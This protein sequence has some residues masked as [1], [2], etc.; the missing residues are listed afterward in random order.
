MGRYKFSRK[1]GKQRPLHIIAWEDANGRELPKGYVVHHIDGNGHNNDPSNLVAMTRGEHNSLHA[2]LKRE[3]K[4]PVDP[5]NPD[6]IHER[7][8]SKDYWKRSYPDRKAKEVL[9]LREFRKQHPEIGIAYAKQYQLTHKDAVVASRRKRYLA[10]KEKMNAESRAYKNAHRDETIA[11]AREYYAKNKPLLLA[12]DSLRRAIKTGMSK[13]EIARRQ[14]VVDSLI[15]E[16]LKRE[17]K[18]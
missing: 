14:S 11:Y 17:K 18:Q 9:R 13:D 7:E 6:V 8:R 3:G 2:K 15:Q 5:N 12:K 10:N 4:D 16:K 1:N